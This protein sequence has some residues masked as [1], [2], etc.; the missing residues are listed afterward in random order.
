MSAQ[1]SQLPG[2]A[3]HY[4]LPACLVLLT[5][6]TDI[7]AAGAHGAG[8]VH[9]QDSQ[10]HGGRPAG[11]AAGGHV[12]QVRRAQ[13]AHSASSATILSARVIML[14]VERS[15]SEGNTC[16]ETSGRAKAWRN[17]IVRGHEFLA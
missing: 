16:D 12:G 15:M 5:L 10:H 7:H 17:G 3:S 6:G 11:H 14:I 2:M 13:E 4:L 1:H 9:R 8:Y